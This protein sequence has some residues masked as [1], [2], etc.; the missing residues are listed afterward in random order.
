MQHENSHKTV[1]E[2]IDSFESFQLCGPR[3][4]AALRLN[5]RDAPIDILADSTDWSAITKGRPVYDF[6]ASD[7]R[8]LMPRPRDILLSLAEHKEEKSF[9]MRMG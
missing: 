9:T 7:L 2:L 3:Q 5:G 4:I 1:Q 6:R 8:D